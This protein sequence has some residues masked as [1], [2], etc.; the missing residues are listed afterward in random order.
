MRLSSE[1]SRYKRPLVLPGL[2]MPDS[3][4]AGFFQRLPICK[5]SFPFYAKEFQPERLFP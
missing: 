4:I 1:L 5:A 3:L 2:A